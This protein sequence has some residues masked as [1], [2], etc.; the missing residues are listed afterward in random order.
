[1]FEKTNARHSTLYVRIFRSLELQRHD[2]E[3]T[4]RRIHKE[5]IVPKMST[6]NRPIYRHKHEK[7]CRAEKNVQ[8]YIHTIRAA[9]FSSTHTHTA[10]AETH[11]EP[12]C[13]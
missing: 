3:H 5:K 9:T 10:T 1:M 2:L 11:A 12:L 6:K 7:K 4:I 8:L 13:R